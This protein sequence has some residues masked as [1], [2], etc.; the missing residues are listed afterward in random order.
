MHIHGFRVENY[1]SFRDSGWVY[2]TPS[3]NVVVGQNNAGKTALIEG[4]AVRGN[5]TVPYRSAEMPR[6]YPPSANSIWTFDVKLTGKELDVLIRKL[7]G[8]VFIP[9][10][11]D[12]SD[13][14]ARE[15]IQ[16]LFSAAEIR[17]VVRS[18]SG[19]EF[20]SQQYPSHQ[21]FQATGQPVAALL[22]VSK[23]RQSTEFQG[24]INNEN[25]SLPGILNSIWPERVYVFEPERLNIGTCDIIDTNV[26]AQNCANLPAVLLKLIGNPDRY[27]RFNEHVSE[28]FPSITHISVTSEG[29]KLS[30]RVWSTKRELEREDLAVKLEECGTGVSQALA[31]LYV[32]MTR[33]HNVIVI[34]EP[35]SF[36]HP[37]AAKK[38]ISILKR[39]QSNQYIISTHSADLISSIDPSTVHQVKW[40][41]TESAVN[42]IDRS[43]LT[44]MR[45]ILSDVG[46]SFSD[47]FGADRIIWVEGPT[48][49]DCFP[50][51]SQ[52]VP[53]SFPKNI[54]FVALRNTGDLEAHGTKAEVVWEIYE[55]LTTGHVLLPISLAFSFDREN[56]SPQFIA[57][58]KR[59][60]KNRAHFIKRATYENYLLSADALAAVINNDLILL[61]VDKLVTPDEVKGWITLNGS[62]YIKKGKKDSDLDDKNWLINCNAAK[63]LTDLFAELTDSKVPFHKITHSVALT[64][65]LIEHQPLHLEE[66]VAHVAGL[67]DSAPAKTASD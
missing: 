54:S 38:L 17:C 22:R 11:S 50:K 25:D 41:D 39:Y 59:R 55:R 43:S 35:N 8:D 30:I 67:V 36:L 45:A 21:R 56:R 61:Q 18:E 26:L 65:W 57:D 12:K 6:D 14:N 53:G 46:A 47:V 28:I 16:E 7:G 1:K 5:R 44:H 42:Q 10:P 51:I 32:A 24:R 66:L 15:I 29:S 52:L 37:G 2:L 9:V 34:D 58:M 13:G 63:L 27:Q 48:E 40:H 4:I 31:I 60:S 64:T 19:R 62:K 49:Q 33:E 20:M 23:D 3:F